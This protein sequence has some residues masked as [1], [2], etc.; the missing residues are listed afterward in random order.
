MSAKNILYARF[1]II[2]VALLLPVAIAPAVSAWTLPLRVSGAGSVAHVPAVAVGNNGNVHVVWAQDINNAQGFTIDQDI[3]YTR[4]T[5]AGA[6][7][8]APQNISNSSSN[9][10]AEPMIH[11]A[12]DQSNEIYLVWEEYNTTDDPEGVE[13]MYTRSTDGGV[14]WPTANKRN[15]SQ[16]VGASG[17]P[18]I[19]IDATANRGVHV[20]WTDYGAGS[21]GQIYYAKST[22]GGATFATRI[23]ASN[24]SSTGMDNDQV[25]IAADANAV[26]L[27]W[28]SWDETGLARVYK[29]RSTNGGTSFTVPSRLTATTNDSEIEAS[30]VIDGDGRVHMVWQT[31]YASGGG[32]IF[33]TRSTDAGATFAAPAN[34][35]NNPLTNSQAAFIGAAAKKLE[36]LWVEDGTTLGVRNVYQAKSNNGGNS[37][38]AGNAFATATDTM[39]EPFAVVKGGVSHAVWE[40]NAQIFFSKE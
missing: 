24:N 13:V 8:S 11:V 36:L 23:N 1:L 18:Y 25:A 37:W 15:V 14:T 28:Q 17:S 5:D 38:T 21:L 39:S 29:S 20:G 34:R 26:Q 35:S 2:I 7:F 3:Y 40:D 16:Q 30:A 9:N 4:S 31:Q 12:A 19:F 10:S 27:V 32:D 22:D 33:S 6:T